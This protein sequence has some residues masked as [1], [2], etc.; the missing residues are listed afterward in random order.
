MK[1]ALLLA[2]VGALS[3]SVGAM[4]AQTAPAPAPLAQTAVP[5]P[6]TIATL[7]W[8]SADVNRDRHL[9]PIDAQLAWRMWQLHGADP[10]PPEDCVAAEHY[11]T[12]VTSYRDGT[13]YLVAGR[14]VVP[15]ENP[16]YPIMASG[17]LV[18]LEPCR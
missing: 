5:T 7:P 13:A 8:K 17:T 18:A 15:T 9:S 3:L 6:Y 11:V 12:P 4:L 14:A 2:V 1:L 10:V 16:N